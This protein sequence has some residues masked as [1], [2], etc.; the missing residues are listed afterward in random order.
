M[1]K[2]TEEGQTRSAGWKLSENM[3][4]ERHRLHGYIWEIS[5]MPSGG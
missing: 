3:R 5:K 4:D 2:E 1:F